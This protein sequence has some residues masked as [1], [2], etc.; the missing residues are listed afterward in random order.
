MESQINLRS[1]FHNTSS[2][3][4]ES[5]ANSKKESKMYSCA[6]S[7]TED[8]VTLKNSYRISNEVTERNNRRKMIRYVSNCSSK[9]SLG[10]LVSKDNNT[11]TTPAQAYILHEVIQA[12]CN[13]HGKTQQ[14]ECSESVQLK[15]VV[16]SKDILW[17]S[18][19]VTNQS[20]SS[21]NKESNVKEVNKPPIRRIM[22]VS[23]KD[24]REINRLK[25][26]DKDNLYT[27]KSD[28]EQIIKRV[29][30]KP[31]LYVPYIF[32]SGFK[33]QREVTGGLTNKIPVNY[34]VLRF[35]HKEKAIMNVNSFI[36]DLTKEC[37]IPNKPEHAVIKKQKEFILIFPKVYNFGNKVPK[38]I[39]AWDYA[40]HFHTYKFDP[41]V[42][43]KFLR[44]HMKDLEVPMKYIKDL[45]ILMS[46]PLNE[47]NKLEPIK[48]SHSTNS[49]MKDLYVKAANTAK[50]FIKDKNSKQSTRV[51]SGSAS[52]LKGIVREPNAINIQKAK[53]IKK[54]VLDENTTDLHIN[55][56]TD[57]H[58]LAIKNS[59]SLASESISPLATGNISSLNT[60]KLNSL[61][62]GNKATTSND[63]LDSQV[64]LDEEVKIPV[65]SN[66]KTGEQ[67]YIDKEAACRNYEENSKT[68]STQ[69]KDKVI[70]N[71]NASPLSDKDKYIAYNQNKT[72]NSGKGQ[73]ANDN[74]YTEKGLNIPST[75]INN[76]VLDVKGNNSTEEKKTKNINDQSPIPILSF[77]EDQDNLNMAEPVQSTIQNALPNFTNN[78]ESSK[79]TKEKRR[80]KQEMLMTFNKLRRH[81]LIPNTL[82][83]EKYIEL[84]KKIALKLPKKKIKK[85]AGTDQEDEKF[86]RAMYEL[87]IQPMEVAE[88]QKKEVINEDS[89]EDII[90]LESNNNPES[91]SPKK[92]VRDILIN[93]PYLNEDM[94]S[95][96][97]QLSDEELEE[98]DLVDNVLEGFFS[99]KDLSEFFLSKLK[100]DIQRIKTP[101]D[102]E[103]EVKLGEPEESWEEFS[104]RFGKLLK[105]YKQ[106]KE[107]REAVEGIIRTEGLVN[108][109]NLAGRRRSSIQ[110]LELLR[111]NAS[112]LNIQ[113]KAQ[114]LKNQLWAVQYLMGKVHGDASESTSKV[115]APPIVIPVKP[116]PPTRIKKK[117]R[118]NIDMLRKRDEMGERVRLERRYNIIKNKPT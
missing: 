6:I 95:I 45:L 65:V 29:P 37:I 42:V 116:E 102:V 54:V 111:K 8:I 47:K 33:Y 2:N 5:N 109:R 57:I 68:F 14:L 52:I 98:L 113:T 19:K 11:V 61:V 67:G 1:T 90:E 20:R 76:E 27:V 71:N 108:R 92:N 83:L 3:L 12:K 59:S 24:S 23:V 51:A 64:G 77:N 28:R 46:K 74:V 34:T 35:E 96:L 4:L 7:S 79:N 53:K 60:E 81:S 50:A 88:S 82:A 91:D 101:L 94:K 115:I 89:A 13:W 58:S 78:E 75:E 36:K 16:E 56:S 69:I 99:K 21:C 49:L 9:P 112:S 10:F 41:L 25:K 100:D 63:R 32:N 86:A 44:T 62:T 39:K 114:L 72:Q 105:E 118:V 66:T 117:F 110:A 84:H 87:I 104:I 70:S 107:I 48:E 106:E 31:V 80:I 93:S 40:E 26:C 55:K 15:G 103:Q 43:I 97:R 18:T 17:K 22:T 85:L 30:L 73:K 38:N